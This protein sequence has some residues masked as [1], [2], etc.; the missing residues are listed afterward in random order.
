MLCVQQDIAPRVIELLVGA[1]DELVIG[2]PALLATDVG[3]VIDADARDALGDARRAMRRARPRAA[4][5]DA[6]AP[7]CAHGTFVAPHARSS[8]IASTG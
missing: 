4:S 3:P 7:A 6:A 1:M 2:D 5:R 8:S